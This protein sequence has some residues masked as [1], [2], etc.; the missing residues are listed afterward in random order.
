MG[1][2]NWRPAWD[3]EG[4]EPPWAGG[5]AAKNWHN[6]FGGNKYLWGTLPLH[7]ALLQTA[8]LRTSKSGALYFMRVCLGKPV[9]RP[10][11]SKGASHR[12]T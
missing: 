4:R 3:R 5:T 8:K 2:D 1:K 6:V 10:T 9:S 12:S 7:C 11:V